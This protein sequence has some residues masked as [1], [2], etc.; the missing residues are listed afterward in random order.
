MTKRIQVFIGVAVGLAAI[1]TIPFQVIGYLSDNY[2]EEDRY[3][4]TCEKVEFVQAQIKAVDK[5]LDQQLDFQQKRALEN[6]NWD[7]EKRYDTRD[8]LRMPEDVRDEY[9]GNHIKIKDIKD[10][11]G[12]R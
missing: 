12:L 1:I 11:W 2:V 8:P 10:K 9:R 5:R 7:L 3:R 6:R 4:V